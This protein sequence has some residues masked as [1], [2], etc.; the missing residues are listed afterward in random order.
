MRLR[1]GSNP[2]GF[3]ARLKNEIKYLFGMKRKLTDHDMSAHLSIN[4]NQ[5]EALLSVDRGRGDN[6]LFITLGSKVL[7]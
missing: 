1:T 6:G 2:L 7:Q 5:R 4:I 3:K